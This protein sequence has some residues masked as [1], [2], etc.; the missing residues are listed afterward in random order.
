MFN[1]YIVHT[2]AKG[3]FMKA[4]M[5][6]NFSETPRLVNLPDPVPE[7]DGVVIKVKATG[8]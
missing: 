3:V 1:L 8:L 4:V 6:Q 5:Y 2:A 7:N